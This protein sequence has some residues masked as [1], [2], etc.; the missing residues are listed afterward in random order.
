V[1]WK[2]AGARENYKAETLHVLKA[3]FRLICEYPICYRTHAHTNTQRHA[4][5]NPISFMKIDGSVSFPTLVTAVRY[6]EH[7]GVS[8][9]CQAFGIEN[10]KRRQVSSLLGYL[11]LSLVRHLP[12]QL[13]KCLHARSHGNGAASRNIIFCFSLNSRR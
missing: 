9:P 1:Q 8:T 12:T 2:L 7:Y 11:T 5:L 13:T 4:T 6:T 3:R 10:R